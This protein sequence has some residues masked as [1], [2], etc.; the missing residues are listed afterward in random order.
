MN[1]YQSQLNLGPTA[2]QA[3]NK[4]A[5]RKPHRAACPRCKAATH[6]VVAKLAGG[7]IVHYRAC[8]SCSWQSLGRPYAASGMVQAEFAFMNAAA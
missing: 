5:L 1:F 7:T 3:T 2:A 6:R 8:S 4:P